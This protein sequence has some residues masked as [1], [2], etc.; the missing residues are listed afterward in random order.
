M[1]IHFQRGQVLFS[2][3]RYQEAAKEYLSE[4]EED[5]EDVNALVN[6]GASLFNYGDLIESEK[7]IRRAITLNPEF[8]HSYYILSYIKNGRNNIHAAKKAI[9]E[10]IRL[11]PSAEYYCWLAEIHL[12]LQRR[13]RALDATASA[14]ELDPYHVP[15]I[16]LRGRQLMELGR[17]EQ[18]NELFATAL[19]DN[20]NAAEAQHAMGKLKLAV[21]DADRA[22]NLLTEARRLD[23]LNVNDKLAIAEA[24]GLNLPV[25]RT[26]N[27]FAVRWHLW[28]FLWKWLA[29]VVLTILYCAAI[30]LNDLETRRQSLVI[31][32][33]DL[34]VDGR[35]MNLVVLIFTLL[36]FVYIIFPYSLIRLARSI[37]LITASKKLGGGW[38]LLL[39]Q[40]IDWLWIFWLNGMAIISA[41]ALADFPEAITMIVASSAS[42]PLLLG[43][44]RHGMESISGCLLLPLLVF[45]AFVV[46]LAVIYIAYVGGPKGYIALIFYFAIAFFS[47]KIANRA[48]SIRLVKHV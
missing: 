48:G 25:F 6:L 9:L 34:G 35:G 40:P 24:Y 14:L 8:S 46:V 13:D 44:A 31:G 5:P 1:G 36:L 22:L 20:P 41:I 39:R 23:P 18:A 30:G 37:A 17:L 19:Q 43:V 4:L 10:A 42:G 33:K 16:L 32:A 2:Q 21:G 27:R 3:H 15:S 12:A 7:A 38:S 47:E 28:P 45:M 29:S 11:M 26:L